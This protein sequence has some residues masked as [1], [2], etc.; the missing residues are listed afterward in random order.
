MKNNLYIIDTKLLFIFAFLFASCSKEA[1]VFLPENFPA[2]FHAERIELKNKTRI[3]TGSGEIK[4]NALIQKWDQQLNWPES[5][6]SQFKLTQDSLKFSFL[7]D[8]TAL[9]IN[10]FTPERF[11]STRTGT[12]FILSSFNE[13]AIQPNSQ[14]DHNQIGYLHNLL[15]YKEKLNPYGNSQNV[16]QMKTKN[17]VVAHGNYKVMKTPIIEYVLISKNPDGSRVEIKGKLNNEFDQNNVKYLPTQDTLII[18][19]HAIV[20][21]LGN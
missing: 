14:P 1:E 21:T 17:I 7:S 5:I 18:N 4:E 12:R 6:E 15:K 16:N 20:Y 10:K 2:T 11:F 8:S 19:E 3:F 13:Y 9:I